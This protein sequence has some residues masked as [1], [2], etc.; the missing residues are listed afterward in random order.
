MEVPGGVLDKLVEKTGTIQATATNPHPPQK[1]ADGG[2]SS[3]SPVALSL[4]IPEQGLANGT[5][6]V[7]YSAQLKALPTANVTWS[8]QTGSKLPAEFELGADG[9][10]TGTPTT[11]GT[12]AFTVEASSGTAK[13]NKTFTI[14]IS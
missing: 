9:K 13:Q 5:V 1:P 8:L 11:A 12:F 6:G 3:V 10:I 2:P 14:T 4:A 7:A